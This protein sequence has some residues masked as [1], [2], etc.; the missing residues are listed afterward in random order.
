MDVDASF[1]IL[2]SIFSN[3]VNYPKACFW[4]LIYWRSFETCAFKCWEW[5]KFSP[6]GHVNKPLVKETKS[7]NFALKTTVFKLLKS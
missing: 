1:L 2:K 6:K 3:D 7:K 4:K 5:S